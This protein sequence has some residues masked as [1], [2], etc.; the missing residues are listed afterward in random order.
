MQ[1]ASPPKKLKTQNMK[2]T[3]LRL[4]AESERTFIVARL[5]LFEQKN[6]YVRSAHG[7]RRRRRPG[8]GNVP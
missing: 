7:N 3:R 5:H 1:A 6:M 2:R 8:A 4:D